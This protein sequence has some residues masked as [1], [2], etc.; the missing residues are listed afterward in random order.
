M[1]SRNRNIAYIII[2]VALILAIGFYPFMSKI[3]SVV[4]T[5]ESSMLPK[6]VESIEAMN[7]V[8][9]ESNLSNQSNVIYLVTGVPTNLSSFYK[10]N[11][12][13]KIK[14]QSWLSIMNSTYFHIENTSRF[15]LNTSLSVADGI[16]GLWSSA[17]NLT[18]KLRALKQNALLV[19][20]LIRNT[21][22]IYSN[23][24]AMGENLTR[25]Y[26]SL[27]P[28]L[29]YYGDATNNIS[30]LYESIYFNSLRAEYILKETNAYKTMNL[31]KADIMKVIEGSP[32]IGSIGPPS[33]ELIGALFKYTLLNGGPSEFNNRLANSFTYEIIYEEL[34]QSGKLSAV[35]LLKAYSKNFYN[36]SSQYPIQLLMN[37]LTI[38][39]QYKLYYILKGVAKYSSV[40]T[41]KD[42]LS[43]FPVKNRNESQLIQYIGLEYAESGFNESELEPIIQNVT[44]KMLSSKVPRQVAKGLSYFIASNNFSKEVAA[45][46][47]AET[48]LS[49]LPSQYE[50]Y[51]SI[52]SNH[53]PTLLLEYDRNASMSIYTNKTLSYVIS[54]DLIS[55][56]TNTSPKIPE[57]LLKGASPYY[58]SISIIN[59][60]INNSEAKMLLGELRHP[61][62]NYTALL[63]VMPEIL[64]DSLVRL[65]FPTNITPLLTSST[66]KILKNES[67][68]SNEL[69]YVSQRLFNKTYNTIMKKVK[70]VLVQNN[71][72]GFIVFVSK[73]LSYSKALDYKNKILSE[74][75][76]KGFSNASVM[77]TGTQILNYELKNSSM[78]SISESD[79]IST[80]LVLVILAIVLGG[81]VAVA[82]PFVGIGIGLVIA[83]GLGYILASHNA[84]SLNSISRTLMYMAGLG[85][86][87]DYSS[88][89]SKR[90]REEYKKTGNSRV[91]AEN[92][93]KKS[94]RAVITGALTAAIGFGSMAI[95]KNFP[96]LASLG[97][98]APISILITMATSLTV[99]PSL[100]A[101]IGGSR[102]V[103]WPSR[104]KA[105]SAN[106]GGE[107]KKVRNARSKGFAE[108]SAIILAIV[109]ILLIPSLYIYGTFKGSYDFT[110]MMPQSSGAVTALHYLS[111]KYASGVMYPDYIV[112]NNVTVLKEINQSIYGLSCVHSTQL[113]NASKPIL[114]VTLSVYPLGKEAI[115]CT[116]AIREVAKSLSTHALVG[117]EAA[118]NLDL[119]NIVYHSFYHLV[120][121]IAIILMFVVLLIFFGSVPMALAALGSVVFSAIF[122]STLA[123]ELYRFLGI[124][125]PWYLPIV[126]FTAILGVGMDYNSFMINR[127]REESEYND[128]KEAVSIA[129]SRIGVLVIGLS[130]IMAGAFSGLLA[131]SAPG[132]RGMGVA[133]MSGVLIAGLMASFLFTPTIAYLL[134]KHAWWPSKISKKEE[135]R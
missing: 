117:G 87:I 25:A 27:K 22:Y 28:K 36:I 58:L 89:I 23:Y 134:G 4:S 123:I 111:S 127:I 86:G 108:K 51:S 15:L 132:F 100:L 106:K 14:G 113:I 79:Y 5:N 47:A 83:L 73:N 40:E 53:I 66:M 17:I 8:E 21:D 12:T 95:A 52:I 121:P 26:A 70:G 38:A 124:T 60:S 77:L 44:Y 125:L 32:K 48:V 49:Y 16:K 31:T 55:R 92:A 88:L 110:L 30:T 102:I 101:I 7:I 59:Q 75:K 35:P 90:F 84:L 112:A 54:A 103:W 6:N 105:S 99:I 24:Y 133:L 18:Y 43:L 42:I 62:Y 39:N 97:E 96:F 68:F 33:P 11:G 61:I 1:Y 128:V 65:G 116:N 104:I 2:A 67:T 50:N 115:S 45:K 10:L 118:I 129:M 72:D 29:V 93:L 64:N 120:Y 80:I 130:I 91:S 126:V 41:F 98:A 46:Y 85:L 3:N 63:G 69:K 76:W 74:L 131:F 135:S 13:I 78:K 107:V 56:M 19:S 9:K 94:W 71:Y 114:Q 82:I 34:N 119:K 122:G 109:V 37:N 57:E 20:S 81:I